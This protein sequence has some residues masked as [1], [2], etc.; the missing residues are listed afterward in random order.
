MHIII[1]KLLR[2][3][4]YSFILFSFLL[5]G[6]FSPAAMA[7]GADLIARSEYVGTGIQLSTLF[8][9]DFNLG[10][11]IFMLFVDFWLYGKHC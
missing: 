3:C 7:F 11:I 9:G 2:P 4:P 8:D 1:T 6:F 10:I 5:L